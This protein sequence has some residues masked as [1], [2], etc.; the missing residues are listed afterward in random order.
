[1][2][3]ITKRL[4]DETNAAEWQ[5]KESLSR[6]K[7]RLK[8]HL[9]P[10]TGWMNDP[11]GLCQMNGIY[12]VFYQYSPLDACGGMKAW[13][14]M[15][16]KD[17]LHWE[18]QE[19]AFF[20]DEA[21]DKDG[22]YS[23]S[24]F[25]ED[26]RMYVFYTG[27]VKEEGEHD[28]C[29]SGRQANTVLV[30][31]GDGFHFSEKE[32][33]MTNQDYPQDYTCHIRDPKVWKE[34]DRYYM[35]QGGR[36]KSV[37]GNAGTDQYDRG[38]ILVFASKDLHHWKVVKEIT[39]EER[40]GYMWECPDYF[41]LNGQAVLSVSPQGLDSETYRYQNIYQSGYFIL[42]N[43]LELSE[44]DEAETVK[45]EN[46]YEW[47]MGFDFYAPQTFEDEDG[48]RILYG[49]AGIPDA[50]YDNRPTVINGWQHAL[51]MPRELHAQNG[52][53][54][55]KP[56]R[57]WKSLRRQEQK[58]ENHRSY[59]LEHK[60]Y[61]IYL[62]SEDFKSLILE[63]NQEGE[64]EKVM[65]TFENHVLT[66]SLTEKC[67]RGRTTRKILL[68]TCQNLRIFVDT[69]MLEIYINDGESVMTTRYYFQTDQK[70]LR[71]DGTKSACLYEL[72]N[73]V[74]I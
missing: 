30:E 69:S 47:D 15:T 6:D 68:K 42:E 40:F 18:N 25:I 48:R 67:G 45:K 64:S 55:Q 28:Y 57:E 39:T 23:G 13:G 59:S 46:F 71:L 27:N 70:R 49:W 73:L 20:P 34:Q 35:V 29:L 26:G 43:A 1:M 4:K 33:I 61:E 54:Y 17:M 38:A 24:A 21:F 52:R 65:L 3:Q 8:L 37:D 44:K 10:V 9:M 5:N 19:T 51:T 62:E 12:H 63:E 58:L 66:L 31:S 32:L 36:K 7:T 2:N 60:G 11:N 56:I 72:E 16:S 14:H 41:K 74:V 50:D 53:I 22:V